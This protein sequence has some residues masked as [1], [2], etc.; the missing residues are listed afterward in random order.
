MTRPLVAGINLSALRHNFRKV[1]QAAPASSVMAVVKAN[2][3]GHGLERVATALEDAH[4]FG[5]ASLEEASRLREAGVRRPVTLLEGVFSNDE[6]DDVA[7]LQLDLVVHHETQI[8]MLERAG[9]AASLRVWLKIDTGMHRLGFAPEQVAAA[10]R[11][12]VECGAV[13]RVDLLSHLASADDRRSG[14][15]GR[16]LASF[17]QALH[18]LEGRRSLA[19]SGA[20]LGWPE[21]HLDE[22]RPGIMLYGISP[23]VGSTAEDE[24]LQAVM[25][26]RSRLIAVNRYRRQDAVG[27]GGAWV[28]PEDMDVGV[29]AAGYGDGYPRHAASGTPVLVNGRR[30][31]VIGRVSM[32]MITIDLRGHGDARV[33][34]PVVLWGDGLPVEEVAQHAGTIAYELVCAVAPRTLRCEVQE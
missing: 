19:N 7:R 22:V 11:R 13:S 21:A 23:F 3:Y 32:D 25:T 30:A 9:P 33:G 26:L 16:Q 27:Y 5:V 8:E 10:H 17:L 2:A 31:T 18:G 4:G 24:G 20:V 34:D 28:C 29:V 15:T 12:L 6:L 14:Y 1:R